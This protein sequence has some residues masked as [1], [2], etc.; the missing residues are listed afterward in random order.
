MSR[1]FNTAPTPN[2]EVPQNDLREKAISAGQNARNFDESLIDSN[3]PRSRLVG[4]T[5]AF[6]ASLYKSIMSDILA[7]VLYLYISLKI[8][9]YKCSLRK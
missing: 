1:K 5:V 9:S 7:S 4:I 3:T 8:Y 6:T 2:E